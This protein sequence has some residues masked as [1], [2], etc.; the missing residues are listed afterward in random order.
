MVKRSLRQFGGLLARLMI[1]SGLFLVAPTSLSAAHRQ[2]TLQKVEVNLQDTGRTVA[3]SVGQDLVVRLPLKNYD[4]NYWYVAQNSGTGLKLL[5]GPNE[6]RSRNWTP[7]QRHSLEVFYFRRE[8]PGTAHLV[9]EQSY[10]SKP[11]ILKVVD[12]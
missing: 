10:W 8:S 3:L 5:A 9:L 4:D 1:V 6:I 11:M 12:R 2:Q 7:R